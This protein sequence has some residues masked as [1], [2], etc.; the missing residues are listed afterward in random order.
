MKAKDVKAV[1]G[2]LGEGAEGGKHVKKEGS[3]LTIKSELGL[4]Q[5][6]W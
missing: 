6:R 5:I 3:C 1:M 2:K 4:R